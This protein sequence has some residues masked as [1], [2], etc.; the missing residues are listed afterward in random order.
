MKFENL[1]TKK[2][3]YFCSRAAAV[4][5]ILILGFLSLYGLVYTEEFEANHS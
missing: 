1:N 3:E 4:I 5:G 2:F